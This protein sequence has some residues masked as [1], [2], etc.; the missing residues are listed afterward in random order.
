VRLEFAGSVGSKNGM[1]SVSLDKR[2]IIV[3][4][5]GEKRSPSAGSAFADGGLGAKGSEIA[6]RPRKTRSVPGS[7]LSSDLPKVVI[8]L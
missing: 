3:S 6:L 5:G 8:T 4:T 7:A 2:P 1:S